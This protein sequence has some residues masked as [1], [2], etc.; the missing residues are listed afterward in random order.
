MGIILIHILNALLYASVLFLI[1]GGLS[2]IYGVMRIVNLAHGNLYAIG[3]YV[4]AWVVGQWLVG[5]PTVVLYLLIPAGELAA[6]FLWVFVYRTRFGVVLRAASQ[7]MRMAAAL[8]IN[9]NRVYVQAFTLGCFM[10][11]LAG[12]IIVP[13]QSAVLGMSVDALILAFTVVVIGGL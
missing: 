12:A 1:A 5:A 7:D 10:A 9:V 3:A 13:S 11:G 8:G 6:A 2:L 4:T